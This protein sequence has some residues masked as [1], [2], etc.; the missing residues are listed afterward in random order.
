MED[1][2]VACPLVPG[3]SR[4]VSGSCSSPHAFVPRFLQTPPRGDALALPLSFASTELDRGL[5]PPSIE[6]CPAHT[7]ANHRLPPNRD[8]SRS[9][10][11]ASRQQYGA[12]ADL[13]VVSLI[14]R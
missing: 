12:V 14:L 10:R 3:L 8:L 2:V 4:L 5:S 13:G 9:P 1:L 6:T 7:P 11:T